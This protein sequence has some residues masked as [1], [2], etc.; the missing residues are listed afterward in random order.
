MYLLIAPPEIPTLKF[1]KP[2]TYFHTRELLHV[3]ESGT[4]ASLAAAKFLL[5][6]SSSVGICFAPTL[7]VLGLTC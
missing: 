1:F 6:I 3:R 7:S 5:G 4:K 2:P